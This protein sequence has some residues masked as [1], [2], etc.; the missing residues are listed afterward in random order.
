MVG[1]DGI[2][3]FLVFRGFLVILIIFNCL[4]GEIKE[5]I[6]EK[7]WM[8][9]WMNEDGGVNVWKFINI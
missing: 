7:E 2:V 6:L 5:K 1:V 8:K 4:E 3:F 9:Y